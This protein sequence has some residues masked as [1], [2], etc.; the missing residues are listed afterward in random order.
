M[1]PTHTKI[2]SN[3]AT[4][5]NTNKSK[6]ALSP[7]S[8]EDSDS[9][10]KRSRNTKLS[11]KEMDELKNLITSSTSNIEN[12][13]ETS[14]LALENKF[15]D[16]ASK[17]N[18]DITT[19]KASV[20]EFKCN[21][22]ADITSV[23]KC[24][25]EHTNRLDNVEDDIQR[26]QRNLEL[27]LI[28]FMHKDNENLLDLFDKIA[29]V[30]NFDCRSCTN[31]PTLERLL[32]KNRIT[33]LMMPAH[34]IMIQCATQK[35][36]QTFYSLYLNNVPLNPTKFG[37]E[38]TNRIV[39]GENLTRKNAQIF[40]R[41]QILKK[42]NKSAQAFTENGLVKIKRDKQ[43]PAHMVRTVIELETLV[44]NAQ[45]STTTNTQTIAST[46]KATNASE[47]RNNQRQR[48]HANKQLSEDQ[49]A[50]TTVMYEKSPLQHSN[51]DTTNTE[52]TAPMQT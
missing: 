27:R 43:I 42:E 5:S 8:N 15:Q 24:I 51:T 22:T 20:D 30:I 19:L 48:T 37:L 16:L 11:T 45:Q 38:E 52:N 31:A 32:I 28:G 9:S 50:N 12:K 40:K 44:E 21:I 29:T 47:T 23:N 4:R 17:V 36:K 13:I 10:I 7:L 26:M 25:T 3:S 41:A 49:Q 2:R 1:A 34:T 35:Q 33:G 6:R 14:Q 46:S 18:D 39:I